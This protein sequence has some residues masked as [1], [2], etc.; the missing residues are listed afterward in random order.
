MKSCTL[1]FKHEYENTSK[2]DSSGGM[3]RAAFVYLNEQIKK[4]DNLE[5]SKSLYK[6]VMEWLPQLVR[7]DA[8]A[9]ADL[10]RE[11]ARLQDTSTLNRYFPLHFFNFWPNP[12][13]FDVT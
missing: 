9:T 6:S 10:I 3:S 8:S 11:I 5:T 4:C 12:R 13:I 1:S 2:E 7:V